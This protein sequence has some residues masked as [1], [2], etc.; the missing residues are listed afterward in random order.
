MREHTEIAKDIA[1]TQQAIDALGYVNV[2]L[3][4][5]EK[6]AE[7]EARRMELMRRLNQLR[8]ERDEWIAA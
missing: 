6:L 1:A 5:Q 7:L 2:Y 4:T 3:A 8:K